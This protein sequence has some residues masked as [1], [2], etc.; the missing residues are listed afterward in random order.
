MDK[1]R[2]RKSAISKIEKQPNEIQSAID[3]G[4][5]V[6][7]L[8]DNVKRSPAERIRRRQIALNTAQKLRDAKHR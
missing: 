8:I 6:S 4:I 1:I 2:N 3:Y 7:M 5:D